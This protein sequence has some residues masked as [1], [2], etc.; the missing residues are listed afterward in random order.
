[1]KKLLIL[2]LVCCLVAC[3]LTSCEFGD[4][5]KKL[6]DSMFGPVHTT[7]VDANGDNLCDVCGADFGQEEPPHTE[8]ADGNKDHKCDVCDEKISDCT[9]ENKDHKCDLCGAVLGECAD[10]NKD[11]KCDVCGEKLSECKDENKD[12]KC[13]VCGEV[14]SEHVDENKDH[15]CEICDTVIGECADENKDHKCDVCEK[16]LG[17]CADEDEDHKCDVCGAD[18]CTDSDKDF[19]CDTCGKDVIPEGYEKVRYYLNVSDLTAETLAADSINGPFT[20]VSGT[21]I[22]NRTKSFTD[23]ATGEKVT[24]TVSVKLGA[25]TN[26]IKIKVNGTGKLSF[27]IQNGSSGA[28]TQ[29][30][31]ITAPD[32]TTQELEFDG[33]NNSSPLVRLTVD[34][35]EGEW[36]ITRVSG[37]IDI[38]E[39]A[40]DCIT[41]KS[42]ESGFELVSEGNVDYLLGEE[43]DFSELRLNKVF[44]NGKTE[45]LDLSL[46]TIDQSAVNLAEAGVYP[47]VIRYKDYDP[48]TFNI[49]VYAPSAIEL[50]FDAI[51]KLAQNS[52]AGNGVYFNHSFREVYGIG[53]TF[54]PKGLSVTII[55]RCGEKE[56]SFIL[57]DSQYEVTGFDS[58]TAGVRMLTVKYLG[59]T[60]EDKDVLKNVNVYVVDAEFAIVN[61]VYQ[62][63]V[64]KTYEGNV[65]TVV[66]GYNVFIT[67]QQALD[68]LE[69]APKDAK[70]IIE[71]S[72]HVYYEKIEITIPNLAIVGKGTSSAICWDSLYG[73]EDASGFAHVTDSTATVSVRESAY[74]CT[75]KDITIKNYWDSK[76]VFD[77]EFGEGKHNEH[78]ALALL[79]QADRFVMDGG[80]LIGYQDTVEFF[81]GRQYLKGVYI[82][83][84]TD[85]IFGTNNTTLFEDCEIHS[86]TTGKTDGG[87]ITAFKGS[88]KGDE[89]YV[90]YGAIF[91]KCSFT[92]DADVVANGNTAIGRCWAKYAAVAVIECELDG[93]ISTKGFSGSSKNERYVSMN[94]K[95]SDATVKFVEYGN[96]GNG[97]ITEAVAGMRFLTEAEAQS[98][99][100]IAT[101]FGKTNGKVTYSFEWDPKS[102]E[103]IVDTNVYYFFNGQS[104]PTG[105]S[106][107][108]D[109]SIE[110]ATGTIGDITI[111]ATTGKVKA[112]GS[113]TQINA[114]STLTFDV[115]AGTTVTVSTYPNYHGY[116]ING[117]AATLDTQEWTFAESTTVVITADTQMYLYSIVIST[118]ARAD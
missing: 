53:D 2:T 14:I 23:P 93:H 59:A 19:K 20:I 41:E 99:T 63:R 34:V 15:K 52:S 76:E 73:V 65:G 10:A 102:T 4:N 56:K 78:R 84:T 37:T 5:I 9:D 86:I 43:P 115:V 68:F 111:D 77:N 21:Q 27:V 62:V 114:T 11:H 108:Y 42:E 8:H 71:V 45:A 64:D 58:T 3:V 51:E 31:K 66:D 25:S 32:G 38:Y 118:A 92:A 116:S 112:R 88:N 26:A 54:D 98:H 35:T 22:R 75:L 90:E 29:K 104:S 72:D 7:H 44:A 57:G 113:D 50:G 67:V 16:V 89:D 81:T 100:D 39:L 103:E 49:T 70:K 85:F 110:K 46:V 13:D 36:T 82:S 80:K 106:Y 1:M 33:A 17:E 18:K 30:V 24:F 60:L 101:I 6:W 87:Y 69:S 79:V 40:L 95:P 83:G 117:T 107:T 55:A 74:A 48:I 97:A 28:N 47:V 91:W 94:A 105:T 12:H 96:T 109:Q 61:D